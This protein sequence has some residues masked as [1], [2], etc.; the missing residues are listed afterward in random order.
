MKCWDHSCFLS[1]R[2]ITWWEERWVESR[3]SS[4][5]LSP[6]P[7]FPS[8]GK[9]LLAP[10][11][12]ITTRRPGPDRAPPP[13]LSPAVH[14]QSQTGSPEIQT[15][16]AN[17]GSDDIYILQRR[18]TE[19][20]WCDE[21]AVVGCLSGSLCRSSS[22]H[23]KCWYQWEPVLSDPPVGPEDSDALFVCIL[24]LV[25]CP[26]FRR[27]QTHMMMVL[28]LYVV[29]RCWQWHALNLHLQCVYVM[30]VCVDVDIS[31]TRYTVFLQ[32]VVSQSCR[33]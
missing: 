32:T 18:W 11:R 24:L 20:C 29:F 31:A 19:T 22:N 5:P 16:T 9:V 14:I 28:L 8:D 1:D 4:S 30:P 15:Q 7:S 33:L 25:S 13:S 26:W 23:T 3:A 10:R 6:A 2:M 17:R 12:Q 21:V 27:R